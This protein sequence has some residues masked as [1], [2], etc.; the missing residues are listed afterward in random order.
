MQRD[1]DY[2]HFFEARA[3]VF[4]APSS[5]R[6]QVF[7]RGK[8]VSHR[9]RTNN[10][11]F[12]RISL[13][14]QSYVSSILELN[15]QSMIIYAMTNAI[16][17]NNKTLIQNLSNEAV[18]V[19]ENSLMHSRIHKLVHTTQPHYLG[20]QTR[21]ASQFE[22]WSSRSKHCHMHNG[23]TQCGEGED[24]DGDTHTV[25]RRYRESPYPVINKT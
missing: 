6:T 25:S 14:E 8:R 7:S 1:R 23:T 20:P 4:I 2:A 9:V 10:S 24:S 11:T 15:T 5:P 3:W 16:R 12:P 13:N 22:T 21:F 19:M 17:K 18:S